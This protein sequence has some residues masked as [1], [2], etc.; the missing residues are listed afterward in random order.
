V[1]KFAAGSNTQTVLP[2]TGLHEPDSVAVDTAGDVY[3]LD[4]AAEGN[5]LVKLAAGSNTQTALPLS[6]VL[7]PEAVAVDSAG[8]VYVV[9]GAGGTA[10]THGACC[11]MPHVVKLA[12]G[13]STPTV[14]PF[15]GVTGPFDFDPSDLAVDTAGS[16]YVTDSFNTRVLKLTAGSS[17]PTV[18]PFTG[19]KD[20]KGVAV[21]TA[22][23][24][25]VGDNGNNRV[26][27][28]AAG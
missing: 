22:G 14:L 24:V 3:V 25:Y 11:A 9:D 5:R 23:T 1:L 17:T 2:I 6:G 19:L 12:A 10:L 28:L 16:V 20:P 8:D 15:T 26:L 13:S 21:D 7:L 27:K 4:L 18:L